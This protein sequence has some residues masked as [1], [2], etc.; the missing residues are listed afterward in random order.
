LELAQESNRG[1]SLLLDQELKS[2][3]WKNI[4]EHRVEILFF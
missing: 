2:E 4:L 3:L 1:T